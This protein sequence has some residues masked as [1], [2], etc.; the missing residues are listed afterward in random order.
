M[1]R[2]SHFTDLG[3]AIMGGMG[4]APSANLNPERTFPSMFEPIHGSAPDIAGQGKANPIGSLWSSSMMLDHLGHPEW[5]DA[6][7]RAIEHV[8][9]QREVRTPD[10]GGDSSTEDMGE[11]VLAALDTPSSRPSR[12]ANAALRSD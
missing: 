10:L 2:C 1:G 6:L 12:D 11:A 7:M 8:M 4:F 5:S 3:A 9:A